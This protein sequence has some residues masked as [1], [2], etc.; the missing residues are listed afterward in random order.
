MAL[1]PSGPTRCSD[2]M[3]EWQL[4]SLNGIPSVCTPMSLRRDLVQ[5]RHCNFSAV[6]QCGISPILVFLGRER[7]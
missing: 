4:K 3:F 1:G 6:V 5:K 7:P 2:E